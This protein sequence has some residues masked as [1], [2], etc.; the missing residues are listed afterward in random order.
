MRSNYI[1]CQPSPTPSPETGQ[2]HSLSGRKLEASAAGGGEV[3]FHFGELFPQVGFILTNLLRQ[4]GRWCTSATSA[5]P[6]SKV[7]WKISRGWSESGSEPGAAIALSA[8]PAGPSACGGARLGN[9][10]YGAPLWYD[11]ALGKGSKRKFRL[12]CENHE[13]SALQRPHG[14]VH[15]DSVVDVGAPQLRC[16]ARNEGCSVSQ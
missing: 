10:Y 11:S 7:S 5:A 2:L 9:W 13:S 15:D 3:E 16:R 4:A 12:P 6:P 14:P 8:W 1:A